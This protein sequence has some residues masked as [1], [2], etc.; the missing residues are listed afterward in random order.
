MMLLF[1]LEKGLSVKTML[2][3]RATAIGAEEQFAWGP[4]PCQ[5]PNRI[6]VCAARRCA[7][8]VVAQW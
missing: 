2:G 6:V 7:P 8:H 4:K 5:L 1:Y 3:D